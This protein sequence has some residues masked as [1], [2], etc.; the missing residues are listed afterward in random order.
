MHAHPSPAMGDLLRPDLQQLCDLQS[1][2]EALASPLQTTAVL[3]A[4]ALED[5]FSQRRRLNESHIFQLLAIYLCT[6]NPSHD[7]SV[8]K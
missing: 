4:L 2:H 3:F 6:D 7:F 1:E 5:P 8:V